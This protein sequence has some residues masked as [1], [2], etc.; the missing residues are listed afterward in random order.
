MKEMAKH[1]AP[2]GVRAKAMTGRGREFRLQAAGREPAAPTARRWITVLGGL[3]GLCLLCVSLG[4]AAPLLAQANQASVVINLSFVNTQGQPATPPSGTAAGVQFLFS[5]TTGGLA[6]VP[7]TT[8]AQGQT[9]VGEAVGAVATG[10]YTF[11]ETV[12]LGANFLS[13]NL[14]QT[15]GQSLS[16]TNGS[17]VTIAPGAFYTITVINQVTG[18]STGT[19]T[20]QIFKSLV[21]PTGQTTTGTLS[22]FSFTL[23]GQAGANFPTQSQTTNQLG[24]A[25]FSSLPA[26]VYSL[27]ESVV[28]GTTFSSMTIN[29]V[30]AQQ[31]QEFQVQAGGSYNVD[32]TNT[33]SASASGNVTIQTQLVDQNG[34]PVSNGTLSGYSFTIS[35]QTGTAGT[36]MTVV[37]GAAGQ[38]TANLPSGSYVITE[39]PLAG[40]TLVG[41]TI[42]NVPTATG[43]FTVAVGQPTNILVT[44]RVTSGST[45]TTGGTRTVQLS[46]GCN[47][48][49]NTYADGTSGATIAAGLVPSTS[50]DS[51]WRFDNAGQVF[52]AAFFAP[53]GAGIAP[54]VDIQTLNHLDAIFV[55]VT[56]PAT[57]SEPAS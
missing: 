26:G 18:Q 2:A 16:L 46:T 6:Q 23:S 19:A 30:A 14:A 34:Q 10:T 48:I 54:P 21:T 41:F 15:N 11:Q 53:A 33:V 8:Q 37:S 20:L 39:T 52:R 32:V 12:P 3:I 40:S 38:A 43:V 44:N 27:T 55:C 35:P 22:G 31:G 47:N 9:G 17:I 45:G 13:A 56:T 28:A 51:I 36:S 57:L 7:L 49:T 50:I 4:G 29:G 25:T 42:N 1:L 5:P 24:Q